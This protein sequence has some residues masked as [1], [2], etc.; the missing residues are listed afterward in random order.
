MSKINHRANAFQAVATFDDKAALVQAVK[1]VEAQPRRSKAVPKRAKAVPFN[2]NAQQAPVRGDTLAVLHS[3]EFGIKHDKHGHQFEMSGRLSK[4][5]K[6]V[7]TVMLVYLSDVDGY[8]VQDN[9]G[10]V[11]IV[12]PAEG[13]DTKWQTIN[14]E[15]EARKHG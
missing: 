6:E 1:S 7:R 5:S 8:R 4:S 10:D 14:P 11:W 13:G 12:R 9:V 15:H 2:A 3:S